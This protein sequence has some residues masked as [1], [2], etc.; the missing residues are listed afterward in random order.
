MKENDSP[1]LL[2]VCVITYN[3]ANFITQTLQGILD[4]KFPFKWEVIISDDQSQDNTVDQIRDVISRSTSNA[5]IV[6][7]INKDRLGGTRNFFSTLNKS[8]GKYVAVCEGDDYWTDNEKLIKQIEILE[9]NKDCSF[10]FHKAKILKENHLDEIGYPPFYSLNKLG[11]KDFFKLDTIPT[12]SIMFKNT[13]LEMFAELTHSHGDFILF[14]KLIEEGKAYFLNESLSVYRKHQ[15]GV[16]YHFFSEHYL[17]NRINELNEEIRF[18]SNKEIVYHMKWSQMRLKYNYYKN[19]LKS[20]SYWS[21][22]KFSLDL[23]FNPY[24]ISYY[25][26]NKL[27]YENRDIG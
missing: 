11:I 8:R 6:L 21:R 22:V 2:S 19:F 7:D 3:Q 14:C 1:F 10:C 27:N 12:C 20:K 13:N 16:S 18:F 26:K 24:F 4:Q 23:M 9:K 25:L 17:I 15:N 5:Q